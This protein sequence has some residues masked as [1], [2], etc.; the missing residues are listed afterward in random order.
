M[1]E[2]ELS[3][4]GELI[5]AELMLLGFISLLLTVFQNRIS[6]ICIAKHLTDDWLPCNKEEKDEEDANSTAHFLINSFFPGAGRRR[7]LA[8]ASDAQGHCEKQ[9]T[10]IQSVSPFSLVNIENGFVIGRGR[11]HCCQ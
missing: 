9:V 3:N 4:G 10:I 2:R 1:R 11:L 8:G 6:T 5:Y 7:L